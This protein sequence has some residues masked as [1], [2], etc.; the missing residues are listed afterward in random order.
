MLDGKLF[1]GKRKAR[2]SKFVFRFAAVLFMPTKA[3]LTAAAVHW[4]RKGLRLHDN[5]A[6]LEACRR[7]TKH[8]LPVFVLDPWFARPESVGVNRYAFLLECLSDLD[9]SLR[10]LG[11]RLCVAVRLRVCAFVRGTTKP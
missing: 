4:F 10:R 1:F 8:V 2:R 11:T 5:P 7:S 3:V 9:G 6:L